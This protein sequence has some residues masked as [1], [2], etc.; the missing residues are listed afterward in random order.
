[1]AYNILIVDDSETVR[2]VIAKTLKIADVPVAELY[3]A[4]NGQ[5]AL[6]IL[7]E[8]W[9]DLVLA[10]INMPVMNGI[11]MIER[12]SQDGMLRSIPVIVVSTEGSQTRIEQI[13]SKGVQAYLRKPFKPEQ[14]K[15]VIGRIMAGQPDGGA[16]PQGQ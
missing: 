12:M 8:R 13:M 11:E 16:A 3:E 1:M 10:D 9:V 14:V 4:S 5:E 6:D 15:E 7:G 2:A